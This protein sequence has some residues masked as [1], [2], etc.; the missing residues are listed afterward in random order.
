MKY[1]K[2]RLSLLNLEINIV[3]HAKGQETQSKYINGMHFASLRNLAALREIY[4]LHCFSRYFFNKPIPFITSSLPF[5]S[6]P[7]HPRYPESWLSVIILAVNSSVGWLRYDI[8][9]A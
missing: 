4:F 8:P 5:D 6:I 1:C 7:Y 9:F 3:F 2:E